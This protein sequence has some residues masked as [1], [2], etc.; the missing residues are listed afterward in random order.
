MPRIAVTLPEA[1]YD[2]VI[3]PGLLRQVGQFIDG[4]RAIVVTDDHLAR[5][6]LPALR[7]ALAGMQIIE[8]IVPAGEKAKSLEHLSRIYDATR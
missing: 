5:H 2:V 1:A 4:P 8:T 3:E 7:E 6:H